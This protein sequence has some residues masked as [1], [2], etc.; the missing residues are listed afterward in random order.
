M[1]GE[2]ARRREGGQTRQAKTLGWREFAVTWAPQRC[3][4][5][6]VKASK[7][8]TRRS[9]TPY[10]FPFSEF[11]AEVELRSQSHRSWVPV[12]YQ[13][14][15]SWVTSPLYASPFPSV[16]W[17]PRRTHS[18][19]FTKLFVMLSMQQC[20]V[21]EWVIPGNGNNNNSDSDREEKLILLVPLPH[22]SSSSSSAT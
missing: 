15:V 11:D 1:G 6:Q 14:H 21:G 4:M 17:D 10:Q 20:E 19:H 12:P 16:R 2:Q 5:S 13:S 7:T 8:A 18:A 22:C 9:P 3:T